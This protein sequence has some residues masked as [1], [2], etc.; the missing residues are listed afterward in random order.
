MEA[1]Q[2]ILGNQSR[3]IGVVRSELSGWIGGLEKYSGAKA[4]AA[5]RAFF[6]EAFDG[7]PSVVD[8]VGR[9]TISIANLQVTMWGAIQPDRLRHFSDLTDDGLWQRFLPIIVAA[10]TRG[11]DEADT[12]TAVKD[13]DASM[14]R[15]L[16]VQRSLAELSDGAH[17]VREAMETRLFD[18]EQSNALGPH[19]ASF[20]GKLAGLGTPLPDAELHQPHGCSALHC[21]A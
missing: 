8:R 7:D 20:C 4:G 12:G 15:M 10:A 2:T 5:D 21:E 18:L 9:G 16:D 6:L 1:L 11:V 3:G 14:R 17:E 13:Y 19:F